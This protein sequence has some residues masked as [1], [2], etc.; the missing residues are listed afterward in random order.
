MLIKTILTGNGDYSA[1]L[2]QRRWAAL[3]LL[4][5]GLVGFLCWFFLVPDSHLSEHARGFYLGAASGITAG[6]LLLLIRTQYLITHPQAQRK[7]K[8]KETDE[9]ELHITRSAAQIAGGLTIFG[10]ALSLFVVLPLSREAY[11]ALLGVIL[12]YTALFFLSALWL[13]RKL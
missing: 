9:R 10:A 1:C 3:A 11:Y 8:I 5:M 7:T 13:S 12:L 2:R 4:A 6:S